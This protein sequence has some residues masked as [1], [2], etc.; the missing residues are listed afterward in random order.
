M[1][2]ALH[3]QAHLPNLRLHSA[4]ARALT[5]RILAARAV[6]LLSI[7]FIL[8]SEECPGQVDR[9][10]KNVIPRHKA[11]MPIMTQLRFHPPSHDAHPGA[12]F[13]SGC[14]FAAAPAF[15]VA[16]RLPREGAGSGRGARAAVLPPPPSLSI[17]Q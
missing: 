9:R 14:V 11:E 10:S 17:G 8:I 7:V 2:C 12:N 13:Y 1:H 3:A 16:A 6:V 5:R 4:H 15:E